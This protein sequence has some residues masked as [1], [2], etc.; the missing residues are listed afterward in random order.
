MSPGGK[1]GV[2]PSASP[3][4]TR[5]AGRFKHGYGLWWTV[6]VLIVLVIAVVIVALA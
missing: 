3:Q 1:W 4:M 2:A 6:A 5:A